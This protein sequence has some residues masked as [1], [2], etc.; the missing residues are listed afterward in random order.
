MEYFS[1]VGRRIPS[2]AMRV[3]SDTPNF[4][5]RLNTPD[6][7]YSDVW[8]RLHESGLT[9][10][11]SALEFER[12][13][14]HLIDTVAADANFA[15]LLKGVHIPFV[16][17]VDKRGFDLGGHLEHTL[18]PKL[19]QSFLSEY[20]AHRFKAVL[21]G[22]HTLD[23]QLS[24]HPDA[25]YEGFIESAMQSPVVGLFFPQ[26]LQEFDVASQRNQMAELPSLQGANF[27]L[28]G[29]LD[30]T[31]ALIGSPHLLINEDYYPPI[32]CMSAYVH[33]DP[34]LVL[35]LKSYG[36]HLEF[37]CMSQMLSKDVTQVSE[38]WAGGLTAYKKCC[39]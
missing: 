15:N 36:P 9:H 22:H 5:Y 27:C 14:E 28:S 17:S 39:N 37:W 18:L 20:P 10:G 8:A 2:P 35:M 32:L 11:L 23:R 21:Q 33:S 6:I 1:E 25:N 29:G 31:S 4:F 24:L 30:I 38:Q 13:S 16:V 7:Q 19:E 3:F 34:R 12:Q 26:A